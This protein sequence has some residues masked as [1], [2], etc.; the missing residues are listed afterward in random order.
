MLQNMKNDPKW[1]KLDKINQKL[2]KFSQIF[3]NK[4]ILE[5]LIFL[6]FKEIFRYLSVELTDFSFQTRFGI[7]IKYSSYDSEQPTY[8]SYQNL[9]QNRRFV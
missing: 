1:T 4:H 2:R 5:T 9:N 6:N 7:V 3:K 8:D